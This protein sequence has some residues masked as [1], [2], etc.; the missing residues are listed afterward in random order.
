MCHCSNLC[1][2]TAYRFTAL[3]LML[4]SSTLAASEPEPFDAH[5]KVFRNGQHVAYIDFTLH[6]KNGIWIWSMQT[7]PKGIYSWLTRKRP[8]IETHTQSMSDGQQQLSIELSGD[9][10]DK[11]AQR[12]SWFDHDKHI[13]FYADSKSQ[14][15]FE[16][17][18]PLYNYHSINLLYRQMKQN[19]ETEVI[20]EFYKGS[21]LQFSKVTLQRDIEIRDGDSVKKVDELSQDFADSKD[22][23]RYYYQNNELAP[24]KIAQN[25]ADYVS[26]MWRDALK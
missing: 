10:P 18:S 25:K 14:R 2:T 23:I 16:F 13:A 1:Y 24:L 22:T 21:D 11:T 5:Y 26:E 12:A 7:E 15:Q 17:S 19:G 9:Y 6:Q 3:C 8:Y 4:L 20:I